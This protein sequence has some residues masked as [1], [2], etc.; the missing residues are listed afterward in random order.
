MWYLSTHEMGAHSRRLNWNISSDIV[1]VVYVCHN[2][3]ACIYK[4]PLSCFTFGCTRIN[5][6]EFDMRGSFSFPIWAKTRSCVLVIH[7]HLPTLTLRIF[8]CIFWFISNIMAELPGC[9]GWRICEHMI[10]LISTEH[11]CCDV[12]TYITSPVPQPAVQ[13]VFTEA[14]MHI[15]FALPS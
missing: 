10:G 13:H 9:W 6:N 15:H 8:T 14:K 2:H 12:L 11:L 5:I 1:C 3:S 7:G 4:L